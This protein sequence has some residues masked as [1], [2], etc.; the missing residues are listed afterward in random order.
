M[1]GEVPIVAVDLRAATPVDYAFARTV[2]HA[3]MRW[4]AERLSGWDDAAQDEK[5]ERQFVLPEVRIIVTG[6]Q[7]VGYVQVAAEPDALLLKEL[8]IAAPFQ[9][10]G[11][12][13]E[14]L[15]RLL[16]EAAR[17]GKPMT[18]GVVTFNPAFRLY[19]R[20]GFRIVRRDAHKFYLRRENSKA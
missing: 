5:F 14:V 11:I 16:T 8:H 9:K 15:R 18:V 7:D 20:L 4:I 1:H 3:G 17:M 19:E 10:R 2:H 12:G 6:G 13:T